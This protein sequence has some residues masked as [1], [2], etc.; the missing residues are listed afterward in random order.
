MNNYFNKLK[1][2]GKRNLNNQ[3][4]FE[5]WYFKQVS[6]NGDTIISF[7]PGVSITK[8][9]SHAFVQSIYKDANGKLNSHYFKYGIDEFRCTEKPFCIQIGDCIF[10]ESEISIQ[11]EDEDNIIEGAIKFG[12]LKDLKRT[13]LQPNIMGIFSYIPRLE[14]N[15]EIIS[16][17]HKL[18]GEISINGNAT[19]YTDGKG[20][21]EKDWGTSF[22]EKYIWIQ[23]NHFLQDDVSVCCSIASVPIL[24]K[25]IEGFFCNITIGE[26]EYRFATYNRSKVHV[27]KKSKDCLEIIIK[28]NKY[29]LLIKGEM[30]G[31][32]TLIAPEQGG[33]LNTIKE[34]L[35]GKIKIVMKDKEG[36]ILLNSSSDYMGIEV[37]GY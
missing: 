25:K 28:N 5:G 15:H 2:Q 13:I 33:M 16:M 21:I 9:D 23:S 7:I 17:D 11:L 12:Q 8:D 19:N 20:Y 35:T 4:Y 14:C 1:F 31:S 24:G 37:V 26:E 36:K 10:T 29:K 34:G 27:R 22:P 32:E 3:N 18:N 30:L 6:E